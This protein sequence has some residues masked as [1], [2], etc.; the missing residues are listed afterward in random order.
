MCRV[1]VI[2]TSG[3]NMSAAL[4]LRDRTHDFEDQS[5]GWDWGDGDTTPNM[6]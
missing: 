5:G 1:S 4:G 3:L 2:I 6:T